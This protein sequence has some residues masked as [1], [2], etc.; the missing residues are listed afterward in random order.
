MA[1]KHHLLLAA[2][3]SVATIKIPL[4]VQKLSVHDNLSIRIVLTQAAA[5]FLA[6]QSAEQPTLA[7]LQ[8][9]KNVEGIYADSDEWERPWTRGSG[10]LHIELR[11]WATSFVLVTW[12]N[13]LLDFRYLSP[14]FKTDGAI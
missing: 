9:M 3:D 1:Q 14:D 5:R 10:I 7:E 4:I 6:G 12:S 13:K 11:R 2:S 8:S